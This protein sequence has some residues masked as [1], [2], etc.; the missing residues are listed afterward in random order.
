MVW[1][2]GDE[3]CHLIFPEFKPG[4]IQVFA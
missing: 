2:F 3:K 1:K 4:V